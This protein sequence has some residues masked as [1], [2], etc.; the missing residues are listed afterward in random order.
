MPNVFIIMD[1]ST[2]GDENPQVSVVAVVLSSKKI[3]SKKP[4]MKGILESHMEEAQSF[5]ERD[6]GD[7]NVPTD[8]L[9]RYLGGMWSGI[10]NKGSIVSDERARELIK[11]SGGFPGG[12]EF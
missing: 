4:M 7:G 3:L 1:K 9:F 6:G 11:Q 12:M 8:K 10:Y 5:W 2:M